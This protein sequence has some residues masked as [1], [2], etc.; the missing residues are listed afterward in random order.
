MNDVTPAADVPGIIVK[1]TG[2]SRAKK[3]PFI[4]RSTPAAGI[5]NAP[6]NPELDSIVTYFTESDIG[7]DGKIKNTYPLYYNG[8]QV[9]DIKEEIRLLENAFEKG[10][11][12]AERAAKDKARLRDLKSKVEAMESMEP[13]F[14][15]CRDTIAK[16][17]KAL[18]QILKD[19][20]PSRDAMMKR[21]SD[22]HREAV[23]MSQCEI[24]VPPEIRG[25]ILRNGGRVINGK[26]SRNDITRV[27]QYGRK[28]L[29]EN[30]DAEVLRRDRG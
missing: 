28:V 14:E 8:K 15:A 9:D 17:D 19:S 3:K 10:Y 6:Q 22:P 26:A 23:L 21:F 20:M 5:A 1:E 29:G 30:S 12:D 11:N 4:A 2:E 7:A 25:L 16:H 24:P 18:S 13:S 27:W